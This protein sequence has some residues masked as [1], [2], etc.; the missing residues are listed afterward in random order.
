M[1]KINIVDPRKTAM[2][3]IDV[4]RALFTRPEPVYN[5]SELIETINALVSRAQLFGVRIV[6]VQHANKSVL[7]KGSD[8]WQLHPGLKPT[9]RD[10]VIEKEEGNSF[11]NNMLLGDFEARGI[12]NVLITGLVS[13]QCVAA[14]SLGGLKLGL[15][16]FLIRDGHSNFDR[17]PVRIIETTEEKLGEAGV[18]LVMAEEIGFS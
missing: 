1:T 12:Q 7:K 9:G 15:N 13:N 18:H 17:D 11:T 4:Q 5:A 16:V 2:L 8:G 6:Y 14:T 3:V 10:L